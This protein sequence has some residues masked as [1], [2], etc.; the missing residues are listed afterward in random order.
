MVVMV[1]V[2]IPL[3]NGRE[4]I[5]ESG[6]SVGDTIVATGAGLLR[7]GT[8]V[9]DASASGNAAETGKEGE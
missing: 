1:S 2:V 5:V 3:Y 4:Y 9:T 7:E 8:L 6:L